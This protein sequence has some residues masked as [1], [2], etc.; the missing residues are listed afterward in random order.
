[1]DLFQIISVEV[2]INFCGG[3]GGMAEHFLNGFQVS[4]AFYKM[5]CKGVAEGMGTNDGLDAGFG[6]EVLYEG[7]YEYAG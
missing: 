6:A 7:K 3:D 1:M 5:G 4:T 2:G